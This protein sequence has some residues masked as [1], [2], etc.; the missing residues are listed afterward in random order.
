MTL[1]YKSKTGGQLLAL[2]LI[3]LLFL[4]II[5]Y[6]FVQ[7]VN[8]YAIFLT[9]LLIPTLLITMTQVTIYQDNVEITKYSIYGLGKKHI[10][11]NAKNILS[12]T[13]HQDL[14]ELD[15]TGLIESDEPVSF[16]YIFLPNAAVPYAQTEF[17]Y[18]DIHGETKTFT[19][20]LKTK[21][22]KLVWDTLNRQTH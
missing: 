15:D 18:T 9:V 4:I 17:K 5:I 21:E 16:I 2:R 3:V 12:M 11:L 10:D 13:N 20:K 22:Y 14:I 7:G 19:T 8:D 1:L 6:L